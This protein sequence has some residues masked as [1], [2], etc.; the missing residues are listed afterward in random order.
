MNR[1]IVIFVA[2]L[3]GIAHAESASVDL[4]SRWRFAMDPKD[5]GADGKWYSHD[6]TDR[7]NL[8]GI[9]QSQGFG[10]EISIDTPWVAALPRDMRWYLLPQYKAY[11]TPGNV[12]MPYLSQ[13]P[14]H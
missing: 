7:I 4:A 11:T 6:L 10:D 13:P 5:V 8:P 9:L 14:R 3:A 2:L 12:K 1:L